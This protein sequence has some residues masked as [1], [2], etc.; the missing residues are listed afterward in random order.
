MRI[1]I[2]G[3]GGFIGSAL[4]QALLSLG[5]MEDR[6][7]VLRPIDRI[8]LVDRHMPFIADARLERIQGDV[9]EESTLRRVADWKPDSIFHLAAACCRSVTPCSLARRAM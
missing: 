1:L 4:T 6:Q 8:M 5:K 9:S 7:G 3:A 2:T